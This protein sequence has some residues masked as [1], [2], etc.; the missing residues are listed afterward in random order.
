MDSLARV[1]PPDGAPSSCWYFQTCVENP[2]AIPNLRKKTHGASTYDLQ[3]HWTILHGTSL[4]VKSD[5]PH[6]SLV[7][8]RHQDEQRSDSRGAC[9]H[10]MFLF[11]KCQNAVGR[12]ESEQQDAGD[13][14]MANSEPGIWE[15]P[16][17]KQCVLQLNQMG[18]DSAPRIR[19]TPSHGLI[20]NAY[21]N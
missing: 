19:E 17:L 6:T 10:Q 14:N 20:G 4:G 2:R 15:A 21:N 8:R 16:S 3:A 7:P 13:A 12:H 1:Q 9:R 5:P 18:P 11:V